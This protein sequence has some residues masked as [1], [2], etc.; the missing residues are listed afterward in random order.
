M[1][2]F[3]VVVKTLDQLMKV[4]AVKKLENS[5]CDDAGLDYPQSRVVAALPR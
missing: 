1:Y 3:L 2:C 5:S 4:V